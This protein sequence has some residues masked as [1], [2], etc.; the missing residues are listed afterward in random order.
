MN[1]TAQSLKKKIETIKKIHTDIIQQMENL[2]KRTEYTIK[3][4]QQNTEDKKKSGVENKIEETNN[5]SVKDSTKSEKLM[6]Q[7]VQI[8]WDFMKVQIYE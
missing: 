3:H 2:G 7:N 1:K 5:I 6:T 8:I 4:H